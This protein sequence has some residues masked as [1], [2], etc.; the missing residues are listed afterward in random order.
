M[1]LT[2]WIFL[3][4]SW[5]LFNK[6]MALYLQGKLLKTKH[7]LMTLR[8]LQFPRILFRVRIIDFR[9]YRSSAASQSVRNRN[10]KSRDSVPELELGLPVPC[11]M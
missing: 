9:S 10:S 3:F 11:P 2:V 5:L 8:Y 1:S 7:V 4:L 6:N